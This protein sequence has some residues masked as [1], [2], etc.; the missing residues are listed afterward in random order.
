MKIID[1]RPKLF[2]KTNSNIWTDSYI[3]QQML[4]EHLNSASD[5][6]S[7]RKESICKILNFIEDHSEPGS[8]LLDLGCGPG[9]YSSYL[10]EKSYQVTGIDFNKASIEYAAKERKEIKYIYGDYIKEY[11]HGK[12]DTVIMIYCDLGTHSDTDRDKLLQNIHQS[13]HEG[14]VFIFDVFSEALIRD[15][16][17]SKSWDYAP[18]GGFWSPDEY[19]L[20]SQTFHYPDNKAF[21]YQYNLLEKEENKHFIVWDRYYSEEEITSVLKASGFGEVTIYKDILD[22]NNF[23]SGSE[24]FVVAKK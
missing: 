11:P 6:A 2:Q 8:R 22:S 20:L 15:K 12:Y 7:R 14:G 16:Q 21:A 17:E 4:T 24:M 3:Q 1:K 23:T 19:L 9:L 10:S 5:G 18:S 13:L